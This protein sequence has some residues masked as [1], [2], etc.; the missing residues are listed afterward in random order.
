MSKSEAE[1]TMVTVTLMP[2]PTWTAICTFM[3]FPIWV[4]SQHRCSTACTGWPCFCGVRGERPCGGASFPHDGALAGAPGIAFRGLAAAVG[5]QFI[6]VPNEGTSH[7]AFGRV[8]VFEP[9][10]SRAI[11]RRWS[12]HGGCSAMPN[13]KAQRTL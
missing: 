2:L 8:R 3:G 12:S 6:P 11:H 1:T 7:S 5:S 10:E 13:A 4:Q 9:G